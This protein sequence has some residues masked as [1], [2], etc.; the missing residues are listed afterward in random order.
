MHAH[1]LLMIALIK[2]R[3][4]LLLGYGIAPL[5]PPHAHGSMTTADEADAA[6]APRRRRAAPPRTPE[7]P[8][9]IEASL[10]SRALTA[11]LEDLKGQLPSGYLLSKAQARVAAC[12]PP[13]AASIAS[14]V[15]RAVN[16][17]LQGYACTLLSCQPAGLESRLL[18]AMTAA[19]D[20]KL[21][22]LPA[23]LEAADAD[24][25]EG[26]RDGGGRGGYQSGSGAGQQGVDAGAASAEG[27]EQGGDVWRGEGV[28]GKEQGYK[29][30]PPSGSLHRQQSKRRRQGGNGG[31]WEV[32][33]GGAAG[34]WGLEGEGEEEGVGAAGDGETQPL[35][36]QDEEAG[37]DD[38][39]VDG[40]RRRSDG[41]NA[42]LKVDAAMLF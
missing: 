36:D 16:P 7:L 31:E 9:R 20:A 22:P 2:K 25:P 30:A 26:G 34:E 23:S 15:R 27:A 24:P 37:G 14:I 3:S 4:A 10:F 38:G 13:I 28:E 5:S 18:A 8:A 41:G 40:G 19:A 11:A 35:E 6:A 1:A 21:C 33:G 32:E 39:G 17:Q 42:C 29:D 12:L